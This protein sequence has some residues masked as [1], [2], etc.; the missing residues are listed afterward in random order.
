MR[1][2]IEEI[3]IMDAKAATGIDDYIQVNAFRHVMLTLI[4]D[5]SANFTIQFQGSYSETVPDFAAAQSPTN[6]WDYVAV[7]DLESRTSIDGDTGVAISADD[8]RQYEVNTNGL[9]WFCARIT[10]YG[11]GNATVR[12]IAFSE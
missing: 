6:R 10:T 9:K 12:V 3:T 4:A 7:V 2:Y 5:D 11:A 1:S 8:V